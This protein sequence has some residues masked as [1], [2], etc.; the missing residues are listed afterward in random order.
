M[1]RP[2]LAALVAVLALPTARAAPAEG[3]LKRI[4]E[5]KAVTI[6]YRTDALPFSYEQEK[7]PAGYT[8]ELCKRVVAS[9]EQ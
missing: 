5:A 3:A 7:Q 4:R 8:V 6:A 2:L 1:I 9:L